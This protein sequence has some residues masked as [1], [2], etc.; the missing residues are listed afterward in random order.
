MANEVIKIGEAP[1][2]F[3]PS[4]KFDVGGKVYDLSNLFGSFDA[5][6]Q[7]MDIAD[8]NPLSTEPM[9]L[10]GEAQR[11]LVGVANAADL[12]PAIRNIAH[13]FMQALGPMAEAAKQA[14]KLRLNAS[15]HL[16][17]QPTITIPLNVLL[18]HATD[19]QQQTYVIQS[20]YLGSGGAIHNIEAIWAITALETGGLAQPGFGSCVFTQAT[21]AGHDYVNASLSGIQSIPVNVG[22]AAIGVAKPQNRGWGF[23]NFASDK[24]ER[25]S[26]VF[27]P[28]NLQGGGGVIGSIM[29]E[30]GTVTLG[31]GNIATVS[32]TDYIGTVHV[33]CKASLCGTPWNP[34][35]VQRM[36]Y[37]WRQQAEYA[38]KLYHALPSK[39]DRL[40]QRMHQEMGGQ[41]FGT[42]GTEAPQAQTPDYGNQLVASQGGEY[43]IG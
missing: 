37:P 38:Q 1:R 5:I 16:L 14:V 26:T 19:G 39:A 33:H 7:A 31:M 25:P 30:T 4:A 3:E 6:K 32:T 24:R 20:P 22:S 10:V 18:T 17:Q 15:H 34:A 8:K 36:F 35:D 27:S 2:A 12:H 9:R 42:H 23:Y 40:F 21:F 29:R 13:P 11:M 41:G 43:D 28:W